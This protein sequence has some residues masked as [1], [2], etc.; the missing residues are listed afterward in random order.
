MRNSI[1][2]RRAMVP[3][4]ITLTP[5]IDSALT[6]LIIFIVATPMIQ[7][8][9]RV[10]LPRGLVKEDKGAVQELVVTIDKDGNFYLNDIHMAKKNLLDEI[11]KVAQRAKDQMVY[12]RAD[13]SVSYGCV[14]ELVDEM[15]RVEGVA[16]VALATQ[17][18]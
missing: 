16:H 12:I 7:N 11:R 17:K 4:E 9:I 13:R 5:L 8:A 10:D 1:R 6:L 2:Q 18:I 14:T 3:P 15:K